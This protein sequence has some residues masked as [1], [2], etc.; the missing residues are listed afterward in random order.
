[1]VFGAR[2]LT[3]IRLGILSPT[4]KTT[5]CVSSPKWKEADVGQPVNYARAGGLLIR[6]SE[7][8]LNIVT[9]LFSCLRVA[10]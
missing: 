9:I 1:M 10:I 8:L 4:E 3:S 7:G 6:W 2:S 5:K